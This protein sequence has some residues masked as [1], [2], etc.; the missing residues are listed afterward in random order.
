MTD[1]TQDKTVVEA[2]RLTSDHIGVTVSVTWAEGNVTSTVTDQLQKF[3]NEG[4]FVTLFFKRT[5]WRPFVI[6]GE[7]ADKG[8]RVHFETAV[9]VEE[10]PA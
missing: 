5:Q 7:A 6:M 3:V 9:N 10:V 4:S 1:E 2:G 8:L